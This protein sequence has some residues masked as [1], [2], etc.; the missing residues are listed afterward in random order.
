MNDRNNICH[1]QNIKKKHLQSTVWNLI[2]IIESN[3]SDVINIH[4]EE[5]GAYIC[6]CAVFSKNFPKSK[7]VTFHLAN[8]PLMLFD[9]ALMEKRRQPASSQ[10]VIDQDGE[11]WLSPYQSLRECPGHLKLE[12]F[13]DESKKT[14]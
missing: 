7:L 8:V 6:L 4:A 1:Y 11:H 3:P 13:Y 14:A 2:S 12:H 9:K 10:I 5:L